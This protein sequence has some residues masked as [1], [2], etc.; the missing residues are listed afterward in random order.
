M[1][2]WTRNELK[3]NAKNVLRRSF[4]VAF[5]VCLI[6]SILDGSIEL[7][8]LDY[9]PRYELGSIEDLKMTFVSALG[10]PAYFLIMKPIILIAGFVFYLFIVNPLRF[11]AIR[12]FVK[13][14]DGEGTLM[15]M[16]KA[17]QDPHYLNIVWIMFLR[18]IRIVLWSFL[19]AIPGIMKAY[20]YQMIPYLLAEDSSLSYQEV[21]HRS[22]EMMFGQKLNTFILDLSFIGWLFLGALAFGV[23]VL[24][25][26]PYMAATS[27]ELYVYLRDKQ[28][29]V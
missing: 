8:G 25:V 24:F 11:G 19:L 22:K 16:F 28:S 2:V 27:A 1:C 21:F 14:I 6:L 17:L 3:S 9:I 15:S 5:F 29:Y 10:I 12:Y 26:N 20:E 4:A 13:N 18:D 23:G 7:P